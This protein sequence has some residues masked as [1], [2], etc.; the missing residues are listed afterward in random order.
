MMK[1]REVAPLSGWSLSFL[2]QMTLIL[3]GGALHFWTALQLW[4]LGGGVVLSA[5]AFVLP[6]IA[7]IAVGA[8]SCRAEGLRSPYC[9]AVLAYGGLV[10]TNWLGL[11]LLAGSA[12]C[13]E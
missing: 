8:A 5:V 11:C 7:E 12:D 6:G 9:V 3:L 4:R 1:A 2:S 10:L 13:E